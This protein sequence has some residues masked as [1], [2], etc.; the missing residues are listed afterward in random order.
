[1]VSK[2]DGSHGWFRRFYD[3]TYNLRTISTRRL[4]F[5]AF[6]FP[7]C[8]VLG[9]LLI[10]DVH[11]D[12]QVL[13]SR[14]V[15]VDAVVVERGDNLKLEIPTGDRGP[16]TY[17]PRPDDALAVGDVVTVR[18]DPLDPTNFA[19]TMESG[20]GGAMASFGAVL[21]ILA[22]LW[23][24]QVVELIGRLAGRRR[25]QPRNVGFNFTPHFTD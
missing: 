4:W 25:R 13:E 14:G 9:I 10:A 20:L 17:V 5:N 1:M 21:I 11:G 12:R 24:F 15:V 23:S 22:A 16:A 19:P 3:E 8:I 18:Y 6:L 2:P 7:C